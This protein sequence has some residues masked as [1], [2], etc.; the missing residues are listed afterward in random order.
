VAFK[1]HEEFVFIKFTF[2]SELE[3]ETAKLLGI[4]S[5]DL[6]TVR[7]IDGERFLKFKYPGDVS[8]MTEKKLLKFLI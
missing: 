5:T 6:P 4:K 3:R 7:I 8:K 1:N 2:D